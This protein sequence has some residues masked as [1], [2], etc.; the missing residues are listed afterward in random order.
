MK[1][2]YRDKNI[3]IEPRVTD[4]ESI[5]ATVSGAYKNSLQNAVINEDCTR[6]RKIYDECKPVNLNTEILEY[7]QHFLTQDD[8]DIVMRDYERVWSIYNTFTNDDKHT[9]DVAFDSTVTVRGSSESE[10][11]LWEVSLPCTN[12]LSVTLPDGSTHVLSDSERD[13]ILTVAAIVDSEPVHLPNEF[14]QAIADTVIE[15]Y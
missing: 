6:I 2:M 8:T 1:V 3:I 14:E 7:I 12:V 10:K 4:G 13:F 9:V 5:T 15:N 11:R